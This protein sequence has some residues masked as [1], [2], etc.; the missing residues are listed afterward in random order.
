MAASFLLRQILLCKE[1]S[2]LADAEFKIERPWGVGKG[3]T[4][5]GR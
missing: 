2:I 5:D 3:K 4:I 1:D